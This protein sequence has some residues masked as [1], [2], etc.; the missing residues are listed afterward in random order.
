MGRASGPNEP[1][2]LPVEVQACETKPLLTIETAV[3]KDWD[4]ARLWVQFIDEE[5]KV[6]AE[7][8][9]DVG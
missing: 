8:F 1:G 5:G 2:T 6:L 9:L 3:P 7:N 4:H